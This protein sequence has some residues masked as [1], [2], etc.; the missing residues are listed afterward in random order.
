VLAADPRNVEALNYLAA[1]ANQFGRFEE[2]VELL[3]KAVRQQPSNPVLRSNL[4]NALK[5]AGQ[6]EA[7]EKCY[8]R[9]LKS[10]PD[11]ADAHSNLASVLQAL[12]RTDEAERSARS[13]LALEPRHAQAHNNLGNILGQLGRMSEAEELFRTALSI[14]PSLADAH[15]NLANVAARNGD[16]AQAEESYR[17]AIQLNPRD[18]VAHHNL[19]NLLRDA[20]FPAEAELAYRCALELDPTRAPTHMSLAMLYWNSGRH[21]EA[22]EACRQAVLLKPE[23]ENVWSYLIFIHDL[24]EDQSVADQQSERQRWYQAHASKFASGIRRH[25]NEPDPARKLR[26]GYVSA[27]F[28]RHSA[29]YIMAPVICGHD[30]ASF[31]VVCYSG[32]EKEDD[33]TARIRGAADKW[34]STLDIDDDDLAR[35]IREDRVDILVDLSGHTA[36]NRLLVFARK[37]A[38]V[39]VTAWGYATGTGLKTMDYFFADPIFVPADERVLYAEEIVDLPCVICYEPTELLP[40][41]SSLPAS[42]G[43]PVTFGCLNRTQKISAGAISLWA[44]ILREVPESTLLIKDL[45]LDKPRVKEQLLLRLSAG[46]VEPSR[47]RLLGAS[48][49]AEHLKTYHEIDMGLDPFPHGGGISTAEALWMGVP[50]VTRRGS[51]PVSRLSESILCA[52]GLGEWVADSDDAY[53]AT[54]VARARD[55]AGLAALRERLRKHMRESRV[56]DIHSYVRAVEAAYRAAWRRWCGR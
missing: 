26:I 3:E 14:N 45:S 25:Q 27:D 13:A 48:P 54:A 41:M 2:A 5:D 7:A 1:L 49:H 6:P 33:A 43:H 51:T 36:G 20:D 53:V 34:R 42:Q 35:Q 16:L 50:V 37:P 12:G 11:F 15:N 4:G 21:E 18:V 46:G 24:L 44:R 32:V 22:E 52:A 28:R 38:P 9:A 30:R 19:G 10:K 40:E 56:G 8:R 47:V 31:E 39:Q 29:Y 17:R 55:V 23:M